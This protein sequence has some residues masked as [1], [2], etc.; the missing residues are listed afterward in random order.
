MHIRWRCHLVLI[1]L[2]TLVVSACRQT[3]G[4]T[5][6]GQGIPQAAQGT[7]LRQ[8]QDRG[9]IVI[10]VRYDLPAFSYLN[11][12]TGQLEGFAV[13]IGHAIAG[14]IF[15]DPNAVEYKEAIP[16]HA[17]RYLNDGVVDIVLSTLTINEEHLKAVD[18]S[19]VY[20]VA[21]Q[22]LLVPKSSPIRSLA[23]LKGKKI[24]AIKDASA[25]ANI[26]VRA[27]E[28]EIST[29]DTHALA[30]HAME[31]GQVDA[32]TSDDVILYGYERRAPEKWQVAGGRFTQ[33]PYG[34]GV[35]RGHP[36]LLDI[37]NTVIKAMKADGRWAELYK[38]WL[39]SA[40]V[41]APP[42]DDW[43]AVK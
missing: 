34:V 43:Q 38:K 29:F 39:S 13:D 27:P 5:E 3:A 24:G 37:I 33:E 15:G 17:I 21:G 32:V 6:V 8:I 36:E 4:T 1:A 41:P 31:N 9:K 25:E 11:P 19:V 26:R 40:D 42:P 30:V 22:S 10:G 18:F 20:Y 2:L 14:A 35:A 7:L 12:Q 23:D 28:A 16:T